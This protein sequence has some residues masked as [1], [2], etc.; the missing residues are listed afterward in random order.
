MSK[1]KLTLVA[2]VA[3]NGVIGR[4]GALPWR[5][6]SDLKRF[7]A[8]TMGKPVLMGRKTWDSLPKKPLPGRPNLVLSRDA[9]FRAAGGWS[10]S[11]LDLFLAAAA[12][13]AEEMG[14]DEVCVIGGSLLYAETLPMADRLVLTEVDLRPEGDAVFPQLDPAI[15]AQVSREDV[16]RGEG[17]D[18]AFSIRVM[19][20][21]RGG[22]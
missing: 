17:D 15:W 2:A 9:N 22:A 4:R 19:E 8:L 6:A 16:A 13:M 11:K 10:Y 7:K 14:V 12:A 1:P 5:L 18:A 3:K 20:R 21:R